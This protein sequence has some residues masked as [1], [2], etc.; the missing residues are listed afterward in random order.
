MRNPCFFHYSI[1]N[2]SVAWLEVLFARQY[3]CTHTHTYTHTHTHMPTNYT[4]TIH[5]HAHTHEHTYTYIYM[6]ILTYTHIHMANL[7]C[8]QPWEGWSY[9]PSKIACCYTLKHTFQTVVSWRWDCQVQSN[10]KQIADGLECNGIHLERVGSR[11]VSSPDMCATCPPSTFRGKPRKL[12]HLGSLTRLTA[13][14]WVSFDFNVSYS[15]C[16]GS[17][18]L[19]QTLLN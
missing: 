17:S 1:Q 10:R 11:S 9:F 13:A 15:S 4:Q 16:W 2:S 8:C 14:N 12:R 19:K 5:K 18:L 6:H 3:I 7:A